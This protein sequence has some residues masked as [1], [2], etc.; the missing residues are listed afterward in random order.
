MFN[1]S[2]HFQRGLASG[3]VFITA[4]DVIP[5]S[6]I[7]GDA[8]INLLYMVMSIVLTIAI[9]MLVDWVKVKIAKN[10]AL[11]EAQKAEVAKGIEA[12]GEEAK[13]TVKETI[14]TLKDKK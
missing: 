2:K 3:A 8:L 5:Q 1:F 7:I 14:D 13:E 11:S 4:S 9:S 10:K 12:I 6:S